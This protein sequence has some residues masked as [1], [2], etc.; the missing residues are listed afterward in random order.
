M[1]ARILKQA[2]V[3][4]PIIAM[5]APQNELTY[6]HFE[7]WGKGRTLHHVYAY[8]GDKNIG[9][10]NWSHD[11][12][13]VNWIT[14]HPDYRRHGVGTKMINWAKGNVDPDLKMSPTVSPQ[15][16]EFSKA[17]G[18]EPDPNQPPPSWVPAH[19]RKDDG[20]NEVGPQDDSDNWPD[21]TTGTGLKWQGPEWNKGYEDMA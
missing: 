4:P 17:L 18:F 5:P 16:K 9:R 15:G 6:K 13:E 3:F 10:L 8:D 21:A 7:P 19:H 14:V 2:E 1:R 12:H 11:N 20:W